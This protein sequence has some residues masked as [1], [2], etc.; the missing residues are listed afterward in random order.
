MTESKARAAKIH[1][2]GEKKK[3][4]KNESNTQLNGSVLVKPAKLLLATLLVV[5]TIAYVQDAANVPIYDC[6]AAGEEIEVDSGRRIQVRHSSPDQVCV[7]HGRNLIGRSYGGN[8]WEHTHQA[9]HDFTCEK[10]AEGCTVHVPKQ[11]RVLLR[12]FLYLSYNKTAVE[13]SR[14]L[15]QSTFGTRQENIAGWGGLQF[16]DWILQQMSLK[17]TLHRAYYRSRVNRRI[18]SQVNPGR[19]RSACETL[20]R[21]HRWA[22]NFEDAGKVME[23]AV[24]GSVV[25][26]TIDGVERTEV[27]QSAWTAAASLAPFK[28]CNVEEEVG[29]EIRFGDGCSG[30]FSN[31]VITFAVPPASNLLSVSSSSGDLL[32]LASPVDGV[33]VLQL[34]SGDSIDG[35]SV[36]TNKPIFLQD[37]DADFYYKHDPRI[38]LASNL[39]ESP[40]ATEHTRAYC[41]NVVKTFLNKD[42]CVIGARSCSPRRYTSASFRLVDGVIFDF[43][44][45]GSFFVYRVQDLRLDNEKPPCSVRISRWRKVSDTSCGA[46][47]GN[48]I[49][50]SDT[51]QTL[52]DMHAASVDTNPFLRDLTKLP[53]R[54]CVPRDTKGMK[55]DLP[56]GTCWEH[57]HKEEW[58]VYDFT[59]WADEEV[60]PGNQVALS[61]GRDNPIK[62]W[63][64]DNLSY[65]SYPS[66][67]I[68]KRWDDNKRRLTLIGRYQDDMDFN[69]LPSTLQTEAMAVHFGAVEEGGPETL[70]ER[71][72]SPGEVTNDPRLGSQFLITM[73]DNQ[74]GFYRNNADLDHP[75]HF[76][77]PKMVTWTMIALRAADQLRQ[78]VAFALS[79]ILVVSEVQVR[80]RDQEVF[81]QFYDIFV[82]NAFGNYGDVLKEVSFSPLMA[83]MLSYLRTKSIAFSLKAYGREVF[84]DENYAREIMQ[85]FSIGLAKLN[86]DGT[87]IRDGNGVQLET[88]TNE[89]I[90]TFARAWTGFDNQPMRGNI[91]SQSDKYGA[92]SID[93]M[94]IN[95]KFRDLLPKMNLYG[96]YIGDTYPLCSDLPSKHFLRKGATYRFIGASP[97]PQLIEDPGDYSLSND[98][99]KRVNLD[100]SSS[101]LHNALCNP[102]PSGKCRFKPEV[103]LSK[104]LSCDGIECTVN[105]V[106]VVNVSNVFY[107]YVQPACAEL[108]FYQNPVRIARFH[109][110]DAMCADRRTA[111]AGEA[112]CE[113]GRRKQIYFCTYHGEE[114]NFETAQQRCKSRDLQLCGEDV[115]RTFDSDCKQNGFKWS[116]APCKLLAKVRNDGKVAIV[117]DVGT[118]DDIKSRMTSRVSEASKTWI[119]VGW[120]GDNF[121]APKN[122]C[123]GM[124]PRAA[125]GSCLCDVTVTETPVFTSMPTREEVLNRLHIG[126]MPIGVFDAGTYKP[127]HVCSQEVEAYTAVDGEPFDEH[128][129]FK[130]IQHG[131][132]LYL[133][134]LES[135][136]EIGLGIGFRNPTGL[137]KIREGTYRDALYETDAVI[138]H[139]LTHPN[140]PPFIAYRLIQRLVTSNPS[141]RY[142]DVCAKAFSTGNYQGIGSGQY[143]DLAATVAAILLDKEARS[144]VL[145]ADPSFGQIREPLLKVIHAMRSL[146]V[147]SESKREIEF[148]QI[149]AKIGQM[150]HMAPNVFSFFRPEYVPAGPIS[151]RG[152]VSPESELLTGPKMLSLLNGLLNQAKVGLVGC[153]N[154]FVTR[155][156]GINCGRMIHDKPYRQ[157]KQMATYKWKPSRGDRATAREVVDELDTLLTASRL[158]L[159]TK[160]SI[161]KEYDH[162]LSE[163][164]QEDAIGVAQQ[165]IMGSPEFHVNNRVNRKVG[166]K[167]AVP[168]K[169]IGTRSHKAVIFLNFAGGIDS[170]NMLVPH[171][172]CLDGKD[173]Y[174]EYADIR[175]DIALRKE[176]LLPINVPAGTQVCDKFGLHPKFPFLAEL[177]KAKDALL[178]ANVG[179][180]IEPVTKEEVEKLSKRIP[181]SLF[182]HNIQGQAAQTLIPQTRVTNGVLGRANEA[183]FDDGFSTASFSI[184]GQNYANQGTGTDAPTQMF[185][186]GNGLQELNAVERGSRVNQF[187]KNISMDKAENIF[188]E[189]W[190]AALSLAISRSSTLADALDDTRLHLDW[191]KD[192]NLA[193]QFKQVARLIKAHDVLGV[194]RQ[195]FYVS[196]HGLDTHDSVASVLN[197]ALTEVNDAIS[198]FVKEMKA[199]GSW[200]DVTIIAASEF[201]RT[202]TSNGAGTDHGWGGNYFML[203]GSVDGGK[204]VGEFPHDLSNNGKESIGRGRLVPTTSWDEVWKKLLEWYGVAE[205]KVPNV[206][207]NYANFASTSSIKDEPFFIPSL[208]AE[209]KS[210]FGA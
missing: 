192:T 145:D 102:D 120:I 77:R 183:L 196:I 60:H 44:A 204:I 169:R 15:I 114:L 177:Y 136:V 112:C 202:L 121:P 159:D 198:L 12:S 106:R 151:D 97:L 146:E 131:K 18:T 54:A 118:R 46:E 19:P 7:L 140:C 116:K 110:G 16:K 63:A 76:M 189:T 70:T 141:P 27:P 123:N 132:P 174:Q 24:R 186:S 89:D 139:F 85:L 150:A 193:K 209:T 172:K 82:R 103:K 42:G 34:H 200:D 48:T 101:L 90:M 98:K 36:N 65:L 195:T 144:Q 50:D 88:Y 30:E 208:A 138:Q 4:K 153:S 188:A 197:A 107:E 130:V 149:S 31:P 113:S 69:T 26:L 47:A 81:L 155:Y 207:P 127:I 137:M 93:P 111:A 178:L 171:S 156:V 119:R 105:S 20:S 29:G 61:R 59:L 104:K 173:K 190:S 74:D 83:R 35:C 180:L 95:P 23:A 86:N 41:G 157:G 38:V 187:I 128:T 168:P 143:G 152:L 147:E 164:D 176:D 194:D 43:Y 62:R 51:V 175:T 109:L 3:A 84:P 87:V 14:F 8:S 5:G 100:K 129:V 210:A 56:D 22:F 206:L 49:V 201:A 68:M 11:P 64:Q 21:W 115:Q 142:V 162:V 184:R 66:H 161:R 33:R 166:D 134:N 6:P 1:A 25:V 122:G 2:S 39:V 181:E 32:E 124:C 148:N 78:R 167:R 9:E 57:V 40:A 135:I 160:R 37:T 13:I 67:H 182:S 73:V 125:D 205:S 71:C 91:E 126:S 117:H 133:R 53:R 52:I 75:L 17:P 92:N 203:G 170:F 10:D 99:I 55:L 185:M 163:G 108:A 191:N 165:M 58:N 179:T 80:D 154:G 45:K 94:R 79:Q 28:I 158:E 199:Q 96:G 72:G